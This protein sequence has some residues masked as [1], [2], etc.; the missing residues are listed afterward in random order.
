[1]G[2]GITVALK[3]GCKRLAQADVHL[4]NKKLQILVRLNDYAPF[5]QF[6]Y[7]LMFRPQ[8]IHSSA[9]PLPIP[10][11]SLAYRYY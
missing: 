4:F 11:F 2:S 10:S 9:M 1:L 3:S 6:I 7:R 8:T 5:T